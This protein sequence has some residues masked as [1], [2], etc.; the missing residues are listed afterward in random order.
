MVAEFAAGVVLVGAGHPRAYRAHRRVPRE[1]SASPSGRSQP[2]A[3]RRRGCQF[4]ARW[5][6]AGSTAAP[7]AASRPETICPLAV[8]AT[9]TSS[10]PVVVVPVAGRE[11]AVGLGVPV[12]ARLGVAN[13]ERSAPGVL[14]SAGASRRG[15]ALARCGRAGWDR[16]DRGRPRGRR[17]GASKPRDLSSSGVQPA[18]IAAAYA[19]PSSRSSSSS[20]TRLATVFLRASARARTATMR[21]SNS[22]RARSVTASGSCSEVW[23]GAM[24]RPSSGRLRAPSSGSAPAFGRPVVASYRSAANTRRPLELSRRQPP[25]TPRRRHRGSADLNPSGAVRRACRPASSRCWSVQRAG[26]GRGSSA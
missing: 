18:R 25:R 7:S 5:V 10:H 17:A 2:P 22:A 3:L 4:G 13:R 1:R 23:T 6:R 15:S 8:T 24:A 9:A 20:S 12:I 14:P 26:G 21:P 11:V 16:A 19:A